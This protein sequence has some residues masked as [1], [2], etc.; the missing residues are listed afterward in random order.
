MVGSANTSSSGGKLAAADSFYSGL[1]KARMSPGGRD[2]GTGDQAPDT[3]CLP[4]HWSLVNIIHNVT[5]LNKAELVASFKYRI[6][7][8]MYLYLFL[9][10]GISYFCWYFFAH[11]MFDF[12]I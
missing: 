8:G 7:Q 5:P 3:P 2:P 11:W 4:G 12:L 6:F 9:N 10:A 1:G